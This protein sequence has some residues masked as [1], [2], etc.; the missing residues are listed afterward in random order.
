MGDFGQVTLPLCFDCIQFNT[1]KWLLC[2]VLISI[3]GGLV[4]T[5]N[6]GPLFRAYNSVDLNW[7][8]RFH[9]SN[10]C[11]GDDAVVNGLGTTLG[12]PPLCSRV[13]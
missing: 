3:V 6:A 12:E 9:I 2:L 7:G 1:K 5:L 4:E 11:P 13:C 8:L 10:E